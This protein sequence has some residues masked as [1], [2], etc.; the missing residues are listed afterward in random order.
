[1]S[2]FGPSF[3]LADKHTFHVRSCVLLQMGSALSLDLLLI[4]VRYINSVVVFYVLSS[5]TAGKLL[6]TNF[7]LIEIYAVL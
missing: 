3:H 6:L 7:R 1:M 2:A 5:S 4:Q